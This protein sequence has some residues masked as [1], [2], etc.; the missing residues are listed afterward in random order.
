MT[1]VLLIP[2]RPGS[3]VVAVVVT[4][5]VVAAA[6]VSPVAVLSVILTA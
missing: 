1:V 6:V 4:V 3:A 2:F 5:V